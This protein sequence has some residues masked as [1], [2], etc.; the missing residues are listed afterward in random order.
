MRR[1]LFLFPLFFS[2]LVAVAQ[3]GYSVSAV[4][5]YTVPNSEEWEYIRDFACGIDGAVYWGYRWRMDDSVGLY[6]RPYT[7]GVRSGFTY[8]PNAIAGHRFG[9]SGFLQEPLFL[10]DRL[11]LDVGFGLAVYTDPYF[12]SHDARNVFIGH[13]LNCLIQVGLTWRQPLKGRG[14]LLLSAK[15]SHSSNGYLYK[16][17]KGLN[18]L[19]LELGYLMKAV[20]ANAPDTKP[21]KGLRESEV[22][23]S[24]FNTFLFSY[25]PGLVLSRREEGNSPYYYAYTA[26]VGWQYH[27]G[28]VRAVGFT[29]DVGNNASHNQIR[30]VERDPYKLP[31]NVAICA[32]YE[33]WYDHLSLHLGFAPYLLRNA[34]VHHPF[35]ERV[36]LFYHFG[37]LSLPV[38]PF[39]GIALK[40]HAAHIDFIEWHLGLNL[41]PRP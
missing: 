5:S 14:D 1:R 22:S 33:T 40:S 41:R 2:S 11:L 12:R 37:D 4:G 8:F 15:F 30:I 9:L 10:K 36:G 38:R 19:Q 31:F 34:Q 20:E 6:R 27:L 23:N 39:V 13:Y 29:L 7:L 18:Y 3:Q 26:R 24:W 28:P 35:Y 25:A 16:P 17:N 32:T 21:E